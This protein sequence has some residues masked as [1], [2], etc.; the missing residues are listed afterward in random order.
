MCEI[1]V[2]I[3]PARAGCKC[4]NLTTDLTDLRHFYDCGAGKSFIIPGSKQK[5]L[6]CIIKIK[7]GYDRLAYWLFGIS[8]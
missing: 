1:N 4:A 6:P 7:P 5:T 3:Y 2:R 8:L